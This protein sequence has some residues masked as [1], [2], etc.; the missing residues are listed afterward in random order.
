MHFLHK[1]EFGGCIR[2]KPQRGDIIVDY[3]SNQNKPQRGDIIVEV[4]IVAYG[5]IL[6][7]IRV[8]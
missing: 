3:G 7:K 4:M 1:K 6:C 5:F 8:P 2:D